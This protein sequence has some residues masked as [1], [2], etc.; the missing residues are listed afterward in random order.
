MP[1]HTVWVTPTVIQGEK[2]FFPL[3]Y[4]LISKILMKFVD[5]HRLSEKVHRELALS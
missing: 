4:F 1:V 2:N 5:Y 3:V